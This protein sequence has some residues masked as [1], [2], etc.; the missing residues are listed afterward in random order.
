MYLFLINTPHQLQIQAFGACRW[1]S[2]AFYWVVVRYL[3]LHT[4]AC[5]NCNLFGVLLLLLLLLC[6]Y[7]ASP[8][9]CF[10][11]WGMAVWMP[12]VKWRQW[13]RIVNQALNAFLFYVVA[14]ISQKKKNFLNLYFKVV[15]LIFSLKTLIKSVYEQ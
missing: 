11:K 7:L 8:I 10:R 3:F 5:S 2:F 1:R 13:L 9:K 6:K 4:I 14:I 12:L 15:T